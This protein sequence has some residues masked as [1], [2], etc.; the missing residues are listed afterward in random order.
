MDSC[1]KIDHIKIQ[2]N[3]LDK[4]MCV[5]V[6]TPASYDKGNACPYYTSCTDEAETKTSC[7]SW[8]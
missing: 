7:S 5:T 3:I 6:Y 2:S 8:I 1:S 4:E